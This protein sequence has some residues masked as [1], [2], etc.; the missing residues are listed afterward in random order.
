MTLQEY[1]PAA[2]RFESNYLALDQWAQGNR[3]WSDCASGDDA[4]S[5]KPVRQDYRLLHGVLG[6]ATEVAELAENFDFSSSPTPLDME[7]VA[8]ELGDIMWYAAILTDALHFVDDDC[9]DYIEDQA[10]DTWLHGKD[11]TS[12]A[13]YMS[14]ITKQQG[15]L[16]DAVKRAAFYGN[17]LDLP[18]FKD[19]LEKLHVDVLVL[20]AKLGSDAYT[21][22]A[23]NIAKL[24]ARY[25]DKFDPS[26]AINRDLAAERAAASS[27]VVNAGSSQP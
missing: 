14:Y 7:N 2:C 9:C 22:R 6:L 19:A 11:M 8:E 24:A 3:N 27:A 26:R 1:I 25:P 10:H 18:R 21:I 13:E 23:A 20:C 5:T 15:V 12:V 16:L 17:A 4:A